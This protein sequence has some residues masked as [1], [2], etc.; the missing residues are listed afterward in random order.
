MAGRQN[1]SVLYK[2]IISID[3]IY[4]MSEQDAGWIYKGPDTYKEKSK[5]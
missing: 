1:T 5:H 3:T 4:N 2:G